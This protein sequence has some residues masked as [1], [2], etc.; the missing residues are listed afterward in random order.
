MDLLGSILGAMDK[1]PPVAEKDKALKKKQAEIAK[2][3]EE[4]ETEFK[5][6]LKAKEDLF[7]VKKK[8]VF[9]KW[10]IFIF[11]VEKQLQEQK[12]FLDNQAKEKEQILEEATALKIKTFREEN[13]RM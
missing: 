7:N 11:C 6:I 1:P 10:S 9:C 12:E 3:L 5:N 13:E 4:K 2:K 8:F